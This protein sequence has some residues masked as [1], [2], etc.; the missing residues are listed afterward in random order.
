MR[1]SGRCQICSEES[2]SNDA[3]HIWYP[4]NV[5][6]TKARQ[7]VVLCRDCHNFI[8]ATFPDGNASDEQDGFEKW[9]KFKSAILLWR[10]GKLRLFHDSEGILLKALT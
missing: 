4:K 5:Y 1:E 6:E 8:H 7:L 3:H 2:T 9:S 10:R